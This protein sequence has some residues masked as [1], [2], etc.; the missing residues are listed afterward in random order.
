[1]AG[2][3]FTVDSHLY[4]NTVYGADRIVYGKVTCNATESS[5]VV[6]LKHIRYAD[7]VASSM[8]SAYGN[9]TWTT[10]S[11]ITIGSATSGDDYH[12]FAIGN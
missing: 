12:V 5:F 8:T 6:G 1:M 9:I 10:A 7:I 2:A 4:G 3:T 11:T